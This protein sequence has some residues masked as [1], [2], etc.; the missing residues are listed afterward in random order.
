VKGTSALYSCNRAADVKLEQTPVK[1]PEKEPL[2][3]LKRKA[4]TNLH[5]SLSL[6]KENG[7]RQRG[8]E[9]FL[10]QSRGGPRSLLPVP[11]RRKAYIETVEDREYDHAPHGGAG[12]LPDGEGILLEIEHVSS[13]CGGSRLLSPAPLRRKAYVETVEDREYSHAPHGGAGYLP[14]SEGIIL[15][16]EHVSGEITS[17]AST[18]D[19]ANT[20]DTADIVM[21]DDIVASTVANTVEKKVILLL[22]DSVRT[23]PFM[24][25]GVEASMTFAEDMVDV[26]D[27]LQASSTVNLTAD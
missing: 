15:E 11:L 23:K 13:S 2:R 8:L 12:Y 25:D 19:S 5:P 21:G 26:R 20:A 24:E 4:Q 9:S 6:S 16:I 14:A 27:F 18:A 3:T 10:V 17:P 1:L 7:K 22:E